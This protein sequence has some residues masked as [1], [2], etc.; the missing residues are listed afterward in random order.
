[1]NMM[2]MTTK[3]KR[4]KIK[5]STKMQKMRIARKLVVAPME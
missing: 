5:M 4:T 1:M 3:R 2:K